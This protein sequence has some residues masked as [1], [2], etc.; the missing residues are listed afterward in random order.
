M[1]R[2]IIRMFKNKNIHAEIIN[3]EG[4]RDAYYV[5]SDCST[6][7]IWSTLAG[8]ARDVIVFGFS[9]IDGKPATLFRIKV[10]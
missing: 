5:T 2:R 9:T 7:D 8:I 6:S 1:K 4:T 3:V 10:A